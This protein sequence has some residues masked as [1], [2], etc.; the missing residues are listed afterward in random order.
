MDDARPS[1]LMYVPTRSAVP[2]TNRSAITGYLGYAFGWDTA[3]E[4]AM[5]LLPAGRDVVVVVEAE[6]GVTYTVVVSE[7][8]A[9]DVGHGAACRLPACPHLRPLCPPGS[10]ISLPPL[11]PG[12]RPLPSSFPP[13]GDHHDPAMDRHRISFSI[14]SQDA[15]SDSDTD[16]DAAADAAAAAAAAAAE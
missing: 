5:P 6:G 9:R 12:N 15:A 7:R 2:G 8:R 1:S 3:I 4:S 13:T 11:P 10:P 16:S 14:S